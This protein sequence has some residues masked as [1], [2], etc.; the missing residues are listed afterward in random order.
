MNERLSAC[1]CGARPTAPSLPSI[2]M[3]EFKVELYANFGTGEPWVARLMLGLQDLVY[4]I[5][6]FGETRDAFMNEMGE[7]FES[8]G[9][10]FEELRTPGKRAAEAALALDISRS[11]ASSTATCRRLTRIA[12]KRR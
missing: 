4:A 9:M 5:P 11:Y 12:S 1:V 8:L 2:L 3:D 10:A 6:A 7:V